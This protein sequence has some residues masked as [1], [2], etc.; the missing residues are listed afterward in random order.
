MEALYAT[1]AAL[2]ANDRPRAAAAIAPLTGTDRADT[3]LTRLA[4][5][6]FLPRAAQ[7]TARPASA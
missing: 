1:A 7:A 6:P 5:F 2:R 4:N 3:T